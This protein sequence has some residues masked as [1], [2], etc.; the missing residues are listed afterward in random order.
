MT[1]FGDF[2][3]SQDAAQ[4]VAHL[5]TGRPDVDVA[6]DI[7]AEM[8]AKL[9]D[10]C[11]A[12]DRAKVAGFEVTFNLGKRWDGKQVIAQLTIAKHF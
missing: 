6:A 10:V 8:V 1:D 7:K 5:V 4:K 12:I 3:G 9:E 2:P 11:A